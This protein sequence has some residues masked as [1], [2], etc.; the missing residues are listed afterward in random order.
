VW[1]VPTCW[2]RS[3]SNGDFQEQRGGF[4]R[5]GDN[6]TSQSWNKY[7]LAAHESEQTW[8]QD[9]ACHTNGNTNYIHP[10]VDQHQLT[11]HIENAEA[12]KLN[13]VNVHTINTFSPSQNQP[14]VGTKCK[15]VI[16]SYAM[17]CLH[18]MPLV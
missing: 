16:V 4:R 10:S 11:S 12:A 9:I 2:T 15:S 5:T 7:R 1:S 6:T 13:T 18:F 17:A 3:L 14:T 8:D